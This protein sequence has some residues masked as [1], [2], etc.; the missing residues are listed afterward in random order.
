MRMSALF[1]AALATVMSGAASADDDTT[2]Y[3][4]GTIITMNPAQPEAEALVVRNGRIVAV[5]SEA[6]VL[7]GHPGARTFELAGRTL[8]PGFID[9]HSHFSQAAISLSWVNVS[10]PPISGGGDA[11]GVIDLLKSSD[12]YKAIL[13][14]RAAGKAND[15]LLMG[16]G[17]DDSFPSMPCYDTAPTPCR[18]GLMH[19]DLDAAFPDIP[20]ILVHVSMHGG[21]LNRTALTTSFGGKPPI[22]LTPTAPL[23]ADSQRKPAPNDKELVGIL[24][25]LP[26]LAFVSSLPPVTRDGFIDSLRGAQTLY[27]SYGYTTVH[28]SPIDPNILPMYYAAAE[29]KAL[30][31]DVVG[32]A[33]QTTFYDPQYL[34]TDF[35]GP[36]VDH[37]RLAGV[38]TIIDGSPQART[39]LFAQ[40]YVGPGPDGRP[41]WRGNPPSTNQQ[42]LSVLLSTAYRHKAHVLAHA[43]GDA[44]V[45]MLLLAHRDAGAPRGMRTTPIHAQF[46]SPEQLKAFAEYEFTP[47]FFTAHAYYWGD[48]HRTNLGDRR[49]DFLSPMKSGQRLGLRMTNHSDYIVT[50]PDPLFILWS[51]VRRVSRSGAVIGAGERLTPAEGLKALTSD[52]AYQYFEEAG[53]GMLAPGM[54]ADFVVLD[55]NPLDMADTPDDILRIT[56]LKTIKDGEVV[57]ECDSPD[58]PGYPCKPHR[59][60]DLILGGMAK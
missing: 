1:A 57:F 47:S 53:K 40:P 39:S 54:V 23:Y 51:S 16:F 45:D 12:A 56:V 4:G 22:G 7:R 20:V 58:Y 49:A 5:G 52:G 6:A 3:R 59:A 19:D 30:Y 48:V 37:F 29:R 14:D 43:N 25:E 10:P 55:G 60:V 9:G 41:F 31:L 46:T 34:K 18:R 15:T 33:D 32:Y 2:L 17:Y 35:R 8:L 38:K 27:A 26:W 13:K 44:A 11:Q 21:L 24:M 50:P 42:D 28:D 36:Y